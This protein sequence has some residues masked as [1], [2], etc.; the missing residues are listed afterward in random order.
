LYEYPRLARKRHKGA[1]YRFPAFNIFSAAGLVFYSPRYY[2]GKGFLGRVFLRFFDGV[3]LSVYQFCV[4]MGYDG[5][6][7]VD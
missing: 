5:P 2:I 1:D 6:L 3:E 7:A 4:R